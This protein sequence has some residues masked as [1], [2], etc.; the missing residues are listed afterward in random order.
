MSAWRIAQGTTAEC[1]ELPVQVKEGSS[2][3][4]SK[5]R[6]HGSRGAGSILTAGTVEAKLHAWLG[7]ARRDTWAQYCVTANSYIPCPNSLMD[8]AYRECSFA[9]TGQQGTLEEQN[10]ELLGIN[11]CTRL[12]RGGPVTDTVQ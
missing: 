4:V 3:V 7:T 12:R 5:E 11:G 8:C 2:M 10:V 6:R 9:R 1:G